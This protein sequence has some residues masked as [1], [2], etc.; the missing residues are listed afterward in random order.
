MSL[1]SDDQNEPSL[2]THPTQ[3][4]DNTNEQPAPLAPA[5][6]QPIHYE[7]NTPLLYEDNTTAL[8]E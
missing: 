4:Q 8:Y 5:A 3:G 2:D 1:Y 6:M 7:D